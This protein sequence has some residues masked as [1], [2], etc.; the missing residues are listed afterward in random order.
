MIFGHFTHKH[1]YIGSPTNKGGK[2]KLN[3][4]FMRTSQHATKNVNTY[5]MTTFGLYYT[6]TLTNSAIRHEAS[7]KHQRVKTSQI[8]FVF[9]QVFTISNMV[10]VL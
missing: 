9:Q 10:G 8:S 3:D 6:S 1:K 7:Y 5:D 2:Y 4:R